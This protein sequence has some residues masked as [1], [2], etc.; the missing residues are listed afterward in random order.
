MVLKVHTGKKMS[1]LKAGAEESG[2]AYKIV[3]WIHVS[4]PAQR[5]ILS[6]S[7]I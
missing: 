5:S 3:K 4:H 1:P 6:E 2:Y 7:K